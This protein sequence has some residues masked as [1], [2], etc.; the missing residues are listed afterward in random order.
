MT[1]VSAWAKILWSQKG[2]FKYRK[3][4]S[5]YICLFSDPRLRSARFR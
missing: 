2:G 5:V 4:V 3:A 1:I